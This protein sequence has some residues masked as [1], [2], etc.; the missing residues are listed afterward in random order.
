MNP[1]SFFQTWGTTASA[2]YDALKPS[3]TRRAIP[4]SIVRSADQKLKDRGRR[5][6]S[7]KTGRAQDNFTLAAW[8]IRTYL[9]H[10]STLSFNPTTQNP[11][12]DLA[13]EEWYKEWSLRENCD[14][15][16]KHPFR[17]LIRIMEGRRLIDGDVFCM[18]IGGNGPG[19]GTI[20]LIEADRIASPEGSRTSGVSL[21]SVPRNLD[22]NNFINGVRVA[23]SGRAM[24]Y[25]VNKRNDDGTLQFERNVSAANIVQHGFFN[26][27]DQVRGISPFTA[28]LNTMADI[29]DAFDHTSA[30]I[31]MSALFAAVITQDKEMGFAGAYEDGSGTAGLSLDFEEGPQIW[32]LNP[33]EDIRT[34]SANGA[35]DGPSLDYMKVLVQLSLKALDLPMSFYSEDFTNYYGSRGAAILFKKSVQPKQQDLMDSLNE[36]MTWRLGMAVKDGELKLP[37]GASFDDLTWEWIPSGMELWDP[38]KEVAGYKSA[39]AAGLDS[40]QRICRLIGTDFD[41][42]IADIQQAQQAAEAAGIILDFAASSSSNHNMDEGDVTD[43]Q[44]QSETS[45]E[46]DEVEADDETRNETKDSKDGVIN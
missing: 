8:M 14:V 33:G 31:K 27:V 20:Q 10:V 38:V 6:M 12:L 18:K 1:F 40:P 42:N 21:E 5:S 17:K 43:N 25:M 3:K 22:P 11:E 46:A 19:R 35:I 13:V 26:R 23:K 15:A 44:P 24:F 16:G 32:D 39:I 34:V 28:A 9:D 4:P 30:K 37:G 41:Q 29:Y 36:I 45:R 2:Y 7:A